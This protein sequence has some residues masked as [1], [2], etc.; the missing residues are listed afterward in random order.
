MTML[1]RILKNELTQTRIRVSFF[2]AIL[3]LTTLIIALKGLPNDPVAIAILGL[4]LVG[5]S[6]IFWSQLEHADR[7]HDDIRQIERR[8]RK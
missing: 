1:L 2:G 6:Y 8:A 4:A 7:L 3:F 5:N